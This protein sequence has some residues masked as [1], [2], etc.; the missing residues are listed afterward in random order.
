MVNKKVVSA[1]AILAF[2]GSFCAGVSYGAGNQQSSDQKNQ[3]SAFGR[4]GNQGEGFNEDQTIK[5]KGRSPESR[6]NQD[7][8][9]NLGGARPVIEGQVVQAEGDNYVIKDKS[10]SEV[11][12]RVN[13]DTNMDCAKAGGQ[14][15]SVS[16]GRQGN[17]QG[18]MAPTAHMQERM[19]GQQGRDTSSDAAT[20]RTGDQSGTQSRSS[21]GKDSGG[22]IAR[23]SGFN[24]G[25]KGGCAFKT[26]D[27]VRA[28]VSDLG[29]VTFLRYLSDTDIGDQQ[30]MSG[31]MLQSDSGITKGEQQS[32]Q[33][34]AQMMKP[35][36]VPAPL[37]EQNPDVITRDGKQSA[38]VSKEQK[39]ACEGCKLIRGLVL[40][41]DPDSLLVKD[42]AQKEVRLKIDPNRI[43]MGQL[44]QPRTGTF[45][46]GD[47]I[48]AMVMPDGYAWSITA[49]KQQQGQPGV[50]GAPGD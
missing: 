50:A 48:E 19:S 18:E 28:E 36:S 22:D 14:G 1:A 20:D 38:K 30:R 37:D 16:T 42:A 9:I 17:E 4:A 46:E 49:L 10:G 13:K 33:Q 41:S 34:R 27:K 35:G 40:Q 3:P 25:Q 32:A 12:V 5:G 43:H 8:Q 31:Q 39:D 45:V 15:Q 23:G 24:I 44:S 26:G 47:R 7:A 11:K 2:A 29:T 6:L 21:L